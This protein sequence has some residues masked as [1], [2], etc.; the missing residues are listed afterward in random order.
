MSSENMVLMEEVWV[1][2]WKHKELS[3]QEVLK[4]LQESE[5]DKWIFP[6]PVRP[7]GGD[8]FLLSPG[9]DLNKKG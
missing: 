1:V 7:K 6:A 5:H 8:V 4:Y 9:N 2:F 3:L